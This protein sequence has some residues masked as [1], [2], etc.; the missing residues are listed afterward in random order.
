VKR[1]KYYD[2]SRRF[3]KL[4]IPLLVIGIILLLI[5]IPYSMISIVSGFANITQ[6]DFS[7][8]IT[9]YL[10]LAGVILGLVF[11]A[12]GLTKISLRTK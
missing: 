9:S 8:G 2:E 6:I 5:S 11:T 1:A 7:G 10:P 3:M 12:I 4:G